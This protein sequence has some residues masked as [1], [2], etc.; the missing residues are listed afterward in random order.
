MVKV[1]KSLL[2]N[3]GLM[4]SREMIKS[5]GQTAG[6]RS[7]GGCVNSSVPQHCCHAGQSLSTGPLLPS[8]DLKEAGKL[9][10]SHLHIN[11]QQ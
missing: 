7:D 2:E 9:G 4:K 3:N 5:A 10:M 11:T 8:L 1:V 6:H